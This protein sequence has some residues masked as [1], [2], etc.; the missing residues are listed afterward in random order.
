MIK[1][2]Q[3]AR[4]MKKRLAALAAA[5]LLVAGAGF[6]TTAS[7]RD[8]F[9]ISIGGPGYAVGY[10]NVGY[11]GAYYAPPVVTY[12]APVYSYGPSYYPAPVVVTPPV[13]YRAPVRRVWYPA[14]YAHGHRYGGYYGYR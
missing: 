6:A 1:E 2:D 7:A 11:G 3:M 13:V 9:S 8:A 10:S 5:G 12:P 4:P 14:Y